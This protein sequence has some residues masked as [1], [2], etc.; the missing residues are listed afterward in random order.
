[1]SDRGCEVAVEQAGLVGGAGIGKLPKLIE[2][3][4][5][6][7]FLPSSRLI[8]CQS[9]CGLVRWSKLCTNVCQSAVLAF[10]RESRIFSLRSL[11]RGE[12]GSER[13]RTSRS[14]TNRDASGVSSR[15]GCGVQ[16]PCQRFF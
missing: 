3:L 6:S 7:A 10:L 11:S 16:L 12:V 9:F 4:G 5:G 2:R 15:M 1:M 14:W 8:V 13:L